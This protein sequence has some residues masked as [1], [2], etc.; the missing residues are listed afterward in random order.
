MYCFVKQSLTKWYS[1]E[2]EFKG[3]V[4]AISSDLL[5]MERGGDR[6][7]VVM[8]FQKWGMRENCKT[9]KSESGFEL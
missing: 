7:K 1:K 6:L 9:L 4:I 8:K 3:I 5:L 2:L